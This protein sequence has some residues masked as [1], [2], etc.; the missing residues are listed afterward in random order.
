MSSG[1]AR[2]AG[3]SFATPLLGAILAWERSCGQSFKAT[4]DKLKDL[5]IEQPPGSHRLP[6]KQK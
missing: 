5:V 1:W 2:W 4:L 6:Y 3:T